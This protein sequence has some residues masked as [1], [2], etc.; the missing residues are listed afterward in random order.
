MADEDVEELGQFIE[1]AIAQETAHT[2]DPG[3]VV[4]GLFCI[5]LVID[6]HGPELET[7]KGA[8]QEAHSF[9]NKKNRAFR[10]QPDEYIENG[11]SQL[12]MPTSTQIEKNI[13]NIL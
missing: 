6:A 3:I 2:G 11:K 7:G 13:S 12:K 8:A 10:V 5:G 9:L 1:V 4:G